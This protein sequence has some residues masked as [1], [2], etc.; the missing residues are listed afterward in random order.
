MCPMLAIGSAGNRLRPF[1]DELLQPIASR[2]RGVEV[3]FR[4]EREA[5]EP[6]PLSGVR[7]GAAPRVKHPECLAIEAAELVVCAGRHE[8]KLMDLVTRRRVGTRRAV[9]S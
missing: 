2:L 7:T 5:M 3:P 8:Q 4:V 1:G 9:L 6:V